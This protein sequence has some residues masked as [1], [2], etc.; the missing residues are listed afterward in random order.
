MLSWSTLHVFSPYT[1]IVIIKKARNYLV[2]ANNYSC[3][4]VHSQPIS[5]QIIGPLPITQ[6]PNDL[7]KAFDH[8]SN[9]ALPCTQAN[10]P[11]HK[12][13]TKKPMP[14]TTKQGQ[15]HLL[16]LIIKTNF[17]HHGPPLPWPRCII[18]SKVPPHVA[19]SSCLSI[20]LEQGEQAFPLQRALRS[21]T[22]LA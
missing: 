13:A 17:T 14:C 5:Q 18:W 15:H 1:A 4:S 19:P 9:L 6:Q 11:T 22:N 21:I 8:H 12:R 7:H 20:Q 10:K 2:I 16:L 3:T